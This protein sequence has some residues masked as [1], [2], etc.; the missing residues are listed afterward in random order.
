MINSLLD[1]R[2][3]TAGKSGR[4]GVEHRSLI[5]LDYCCSMATA[6]S[7]G[8]SERFVS[9]RLRAGQCVKPLSEGNY[10]KVFITGSAL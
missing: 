6:I 3:R 1:T 5:I 8:Q 7:L 10:K 2:R 9:D 4:R